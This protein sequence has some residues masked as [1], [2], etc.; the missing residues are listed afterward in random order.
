M[1]F[2]KY[3]KH[4]PKAPELIAEVFP[5]GRVSLFHGRQGAGKTYSVIKALNVAGVIPIYIDLDDTTGV[6]DLHLYRVSNQLLRDMIKGTAEGLDG[7]VVIIDTYT[8]VHDDLKALGYK[9][10]DI[11]ELFE[12]FCKR[13]KITLIII[14]HTRNFVGKDGIFEDNIYLARGAAEELYLDKAEYKAKAATVRN[15]AEPARVEYSL[16]KCK[17]RGQ[18]GASIEENWMRREIDHGISKEAIEEMN[19]LLDNI[20]SEG[21]KDIQLTEEEKEM[22]VAEKATEMK[23][24]IAQRKIDKDTAKGALEV[25]E[26]KKREMCKHG[27]KGCRK[28]NLCSK[29]EYD[30]M[31]S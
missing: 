28:G 14:A 3:L 7:Q 4:A 2:S 12:G 6:E 5:K 13:Y 16:H 10:K 11:L 26:R 30:V 19:E 8:R 18:G 25:M 20:S 29:C 27:S 15:K 17:G 23:R 1:H 24:I 22:T 9:D 21:S 31:H